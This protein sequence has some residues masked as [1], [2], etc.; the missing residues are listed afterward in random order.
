MKRRFDILRRAKSL[1]RQSLII[2]LRTA[3]QRNLTPPTSA[4]FCQTLERDNF[5]PRLARFVRLSK[6]IVST[7]NPIADF[8]LTRGAASFRAEVSG[9]IEASCKIVESFA[10]LLC[11][12]TLQTA[13]EMRVG[14]GFTRVELRATF[15]NAERAT[16][17]QLDCFI[18]FAHERFQSNQRG[19]GFVL[20]HHGR[21]VLLK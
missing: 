2:T 8:R 1:L 14:P 9:R 19:E 11:V 10:V 12:E 20:L 16:P 15:P 6:R 17:Q 4:S 13:Y 21:L 5:L 7:T 3:R 18:G